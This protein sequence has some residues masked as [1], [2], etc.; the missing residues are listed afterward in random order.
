MGNQFLAEAQ[1]LATDKPQAVWLYVAP[2]NAI[3]ISVEAKNDGFHPTWISSSIAWGFNLALAPAAGALDG[4]KSF[5]PWGGLSDPRYKTYNAKN[6][7]GRANQDRDIGLPAWGWGQ[8]IAAAMKAAG[9]KL[10][11]NSFRV[12]MQNLRTGRTDV[13]TGAPMCWPP[14][15]F[16]G[17]KRYGSGDRTIVMAVQGSG[18]NSVWAT[19]S[20]YRSV[21]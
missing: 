1:K 14:I 19:E 12:A 20:D 10:G 4:A 3:N 16:T 17:N 8:L 6:T 9:P 11:R 5:S 18:A 21:Y 7:K 2:N 15:D 13:V